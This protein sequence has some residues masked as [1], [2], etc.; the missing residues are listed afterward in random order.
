MQ[1]M[2]KKGQI[3]KK[4]RTSF[5]LGRKKWRGNT[6]GK[7]G[8]GRELIHVVKG[9][10]VIVYIESAVLPLDVERPFSCSDVSINQTWFRDERY[11]TIL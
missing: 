2:L 10:S 5:C 8:W 1:V 4:H 11:L 9:L 3:L 6:V 7:G